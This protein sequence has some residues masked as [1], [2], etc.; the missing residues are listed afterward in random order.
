M[1]I[2]VTVKLK[3]EIVELAEK[4]VKH[5]IAKSRSHAIN[6]MIEHGIEKVIKDLEFWERLR[7]G[8]EELKTSDYRISHGGLSALLSEERAQR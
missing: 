5:G 7:E 1:S 8:V 3:R 2:P 6:L 4:M